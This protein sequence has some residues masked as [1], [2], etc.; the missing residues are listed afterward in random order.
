MFTKRNIVLNL[1]L[2]NLDSV[3]LGGDQ[4]SAFLTGFPGD[5]K[6]SLLCATW[7]NFCRELSWSKKIID[8]FYTGLIYM[9]PKQ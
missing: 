8:D 9:N 5:S 4:E 7:R 6:A 2:R 1:T 3:D